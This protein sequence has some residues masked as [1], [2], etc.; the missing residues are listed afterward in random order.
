MVGTI[1]T[2]QILFVPSPL[3]CPILSPPQGAVDGKI[4]GGE[5]G[6]SAHQLGHSLGGEHPIGAHP[7]GEDD[8]EGGR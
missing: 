6:Q 8:G 2:D 7:D 3:L 5:T 4:H 1:L